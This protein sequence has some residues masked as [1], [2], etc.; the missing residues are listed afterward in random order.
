MK[1]IKIALIALF[2]GIAMVFGVAGCKSGNPNHNL[3]D[4]AQSSGSTIDGAYFITDESYEIFVRNCAS[5]IGA[6]EQWITDVLKGGDGGEW[7]YM[8][9]P[10]SW[11]RCVIAD[12]KI[13]VSNIEDTVYCISNDGNIYRGNSIAQTISFWFSDDILYLSDKNETL[14]FSKDN[15]YQKLTNEVIALGAPQNVTVNS[16]GEGSN[17]VTFSWNYQSGY[18]KF[19]AAV[20]I[21]T[22]NSQEYKAV[23]K[24]ERAYMNMFVVEL[25]EYNFQTGVNFVRLY[26]IGGPSITND[27]SIIVNKN[28][29][30]TTFR[31]VVKDNGSVKVEELNF[32]G[33]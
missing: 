29:D 11:F 4:N 13:T 16:G 1:K 27:H 21:K 31:V 7:H 23:Q 14:Q 19:G 2:L 33:E 20:E 8:I 10:Q 9:R 32:L 22:A 24:I 30:Y 25:D 28:S 18:G 26:H 15:S 17:Y 12:N 6:G 5:Q 3:E